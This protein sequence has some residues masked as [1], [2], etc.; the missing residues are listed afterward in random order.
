MEDGVFYGVFLGGVFSL[1]FGRCSQCPQAVQKG[2]LQCSLGWL[3]LYGA[4]RRD[5]S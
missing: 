5:I 3:L 4:V 1:V 2:E